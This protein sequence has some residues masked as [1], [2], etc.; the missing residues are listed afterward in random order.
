M[1]KLFL[2]EWDGDKLVATTEIT[3]DKGSRY[4]KISKSMDY[5]YDKRRTITAFL[6]NEDPGT[7]LAVDKGRFYYFK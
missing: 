1:A 3:G 4:S 2:D 5:F 6:D 7:W